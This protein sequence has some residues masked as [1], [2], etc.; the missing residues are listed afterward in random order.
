MI[1]AG[2][3]EFFVMAIAEHMVID[4]EL[5]S[6]DCYKFFPQ[7]IL[8]FNEQLIVIGENI[9]NRLLIDITLNDILSYCALNISYQSNF[10]KR[11]VDSF[12]KTLRE[13]EGSSVRLILKID[14]SF[15]EFAPPRSFQHLGNTYVTFNGNG[16]RIWAAT[17]EPNLTLIEWLYSIRHNI[18][19]LDPKSVRDHLKNYC[20]YMETRSA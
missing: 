1:S 7:Q 8:E 9:E 12:I 2:K 14:H 16:D 17:V 18:E 10:T 13:V 15:V 4:I 5:N 3:A 19:I 20:Y 11:Q 6:G